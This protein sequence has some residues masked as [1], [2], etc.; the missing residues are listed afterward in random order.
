[1]I[2]TL[3]HNEWRAVLRDGRGIALLIVGALLAL[4][5]TWT[6]ASTGARQDLAQEAATQASRNAWNRRQLE[7][8]HARAHYGDY[9]FRRSGPLSDLDSGLQSVLGR[10]IHTEAHRQNDSVHNAQQASGTLLRYDRLEPSMV[11]QLLAPLVLVLAG[12]GVVS[13]ERESGRLRLLWIQGVRAFPL[14][15]TKTLALWTLGAALCVLVVGAHTLFAGPLDLARTV[16]FLALHLTMLWIV[17]ALVVGV[18]ARAHRPG[19]AAALL[20]FLWVA[21]AIVLPRFAAMTAAAA[22]PLPSRDAFQA[23]LQEDRAKGIDGHNPRDARRL[24]LEQR[25]LAEYG[26]SSRRELPIR[27]GGLIMQADEEYGAQVWDKHFGDLEDHF[28]RQEAFV[29]GFSFLNPLQATDRLSMSIAGTGLTSH[30]DF[31]RATEGYR[32]ELVRKLNEEDAYGVER[33]AGGGLR[34]TTTREFYDSFAGFEYEPMTLGALLGRRVP[35]FLALTTWL[36]GVAIFLFLTAR[37]LDRR[38]VL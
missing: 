19:T 27:L 23:A 20:L 5:S 6:A 3:F 30:L 18:S 24:E 35:D 8:A 16:A 22:E 10:V 28:E 13:S 14:I 36:V 9:V 31:L 29:G 1:M 21:G 12:F 17:A 38:G 25:V 32:R 15:M 26:V 2:R 33:N 7:H 37:R 11:L 4:G 34:S